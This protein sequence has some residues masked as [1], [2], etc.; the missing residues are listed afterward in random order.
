[1]RSG[2]FKMLW[3]FV[4]TNITLNLC[5]VGISELADTVRTYITVDSFKSSSP[6]QFEVNILSALS[7]KYEMFPELPAERR[8]KFQEDA[9]AQYK[10][11][12]NVGDEITFSYSSRGINYKIT[13]RFYGKSP[14]SNA[15]IINSTYIPIVDIPLDVKAKMF[16]EFN[17]LARTEYVNEQV[18]KW[19]RSSEDIQF[20]KERYV[21][22]DGKWYTPSAIVKLLIAGRIRKVKKEIAE[23]EAERRRIEVEK[24]RA[25]TRY[26]ARREPTIEYMEIKLIRLRPAD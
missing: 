5:A 11:T 22:W 4:I 18:E 24:R 16:P 3:L 26:E 9:A 20:K 6:E 21:F 8:A 13:G 23:A 15:V 25:E 14:T 1:M 12:I 17:A 19:Q 2:T 7:K 10:D